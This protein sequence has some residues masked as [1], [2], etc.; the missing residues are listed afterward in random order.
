MYRPAC[1]IIHTGGRSTDS[2]RA[3]LSN[4]GRESLIQRFDNQL[5]N[6]P[7]AEPYWRP[8]KKKKDLRHT[9]SRLSGAVRGYSGLCL[10]TKTLNG[11]KHRSN[12]CSYPCIPH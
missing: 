3:A 9:F 2:P 8:N 1:R 5:Q 11:G 10:N 6:L 12:D 7:E 4:R